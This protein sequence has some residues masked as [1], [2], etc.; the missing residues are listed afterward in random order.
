MTALIA[1]GMVLATLALFGVACVVGYSFVLL[2]LGT[3]WKARIAGFLLLWAEAALALYAE[4]PEG[5]AL[6]QAVSAAARQ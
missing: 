6:W 4:S 1:L 2:L 5:Q 3:H